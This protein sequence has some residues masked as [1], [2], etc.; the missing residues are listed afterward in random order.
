MGEGPVADNGIDAQ[1][2]GDLSAEAL[3]AGPFLSAGANVFQYKKREVADQTRSR[4]VA[5]MC[6]TFE[7]PSWKSSGVRAQGQLPTFFFTNIDLPVGAPSKRVIDQMPLEIES[8]DS[9]EDEECPPPDSTSSVNQ[10][11]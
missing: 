11:L 2:Q 4:L 9:D 3:T 7:V 5:D 6:A 8:S 10:C 1:W